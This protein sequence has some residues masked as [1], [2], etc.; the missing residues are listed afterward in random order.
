MLTASYRTGS[1]MDV[2]T[3]HATF[4]SQCDGMSS[5]NVWGGTQFSN[6]IR[7][8]TETECNGF[9]NAPGHLQTFDLNFFKDG[10]PHRVK[11]RVKE[12]ARTKS[13]ILYEFRHWV[14]ERKVVHGYIITRGHDG[15]NQ[16]LQIID[17]GPTFKSYAILQTAAQY[18]SNP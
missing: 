5:G 6:Y 9:T 14:G 13:V 10:L 18:V 15:N 8:F 2:K 12:Y 1:R 16:L 4:D 3:G 17:T 7:A 11:E